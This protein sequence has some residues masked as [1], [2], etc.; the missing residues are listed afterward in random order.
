MQFEAYIS[1][2][3]SAASDMFGSFYKQKIKKGRTLK[4]LLINK[5]QKNRTDSESLSCMV[6][7]WGLEPQTP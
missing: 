3:E 1:V 5:K 4:S 6:H 7:L 2:I